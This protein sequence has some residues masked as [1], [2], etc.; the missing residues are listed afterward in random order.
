MDRAE[1]V[2]NLAMNASYRRK[3]VGVLA[4]RALRRALVV[5]PDDRSCGNIESEK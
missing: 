4:K 1:P 3:T 2:G 5:A